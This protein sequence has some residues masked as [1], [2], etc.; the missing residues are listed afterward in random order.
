M[1]KSVQIHVQIL[2]VDVAERINNQTF[3]TVFLLE[4]MLVKLD[5]SSA[6]SMYL[7]NFMDL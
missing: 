7:I 2:Q 1:S 4:L 5:I 6:H 3:C